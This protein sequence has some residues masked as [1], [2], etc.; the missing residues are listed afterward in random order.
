MDYLWQNVGVFASIN[1]VLNTT[2]KTEEQARNAN[3]RQV[4]QDVSSGT[5]LLD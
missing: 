2:Y 3:F 5:P 4:N 1:N